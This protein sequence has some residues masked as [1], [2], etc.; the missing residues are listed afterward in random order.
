MVVVRA[1]TNIRRWISSGVDDSLMAF[2]FVF[3]FLVLGS[4]LVLSSS[5]GPTFGLVGR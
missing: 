2:L 5:P 1:K 3:Q 4:Y